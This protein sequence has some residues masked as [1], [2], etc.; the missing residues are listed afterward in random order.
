MSAGRRQAS[1]ATQGSASGA[2][3]DASAPRRRHRGRV[4]ALLVAGGIVTLAVSRGARNRV[5][6]IVFGPEEEFE[7]ESETE[8]AAFGLGPRESSAPASEAEQPPE[9]E[10]QAQERAD[11]E[12]VAELEELESA[13]TG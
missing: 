4:G 13:I 12:W 7:Y 3:S 9:G 8:P 10:E 6:D 5:L 11:R 1:D 2:G